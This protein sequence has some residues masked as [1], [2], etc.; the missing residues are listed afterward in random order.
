MGSEGV[1]PHII[2]MLTDGHPT[3]GITHSESILKNVREKNKEGASIFC[4][5]FGRGADMELLE[6]IAHQV[7]TFW[8]VC[9]LWRVTQM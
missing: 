4:L 9:Y 8:N 5:G 6:R 3:V 7:S 1:R 2:I